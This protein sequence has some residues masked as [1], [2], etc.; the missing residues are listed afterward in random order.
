MDE[1]LRRAED[2]IKDL[3]RIQEKQGEKLEKVVIT[4]TKYE[5]D[6]SGIHES[7]RNIETHITKLNEYRE[8]DLNKTVNLKDYLVQIVVAG[9]VMYAVSLI[10][11]I[12]L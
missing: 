8:A 1:R 10:L 12:N 3:R 5:G 4:Q 11:G 6:I 9:L 2:D 7:I